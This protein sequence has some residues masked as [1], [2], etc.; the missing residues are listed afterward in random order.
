M[1]LRRDQDPMDHLRRRQDLVR[2]ADEFRLSPNEI[3]MYIPGWSPRPY[4][5]DSTTTPQ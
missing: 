2:L 5:G 1:N 3:D 4:S